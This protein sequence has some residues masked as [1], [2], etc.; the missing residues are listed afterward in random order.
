MPSGIN[1]EGSSRAQPRDQR[2]G[3]FAY[4]NILTL[5]PTH[6]TTQPA[7][8]ALNDAAAQSHHHPKRRSTIGVQVDLTHGRERVCLDIDGSKPVYFVGPGVGP[9]AEALS[10]GCTDR[11]R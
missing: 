5:S 10:T 11:W 2:E 8:T 3:P 4:Q 6:P 1:Q 9:L 7:I